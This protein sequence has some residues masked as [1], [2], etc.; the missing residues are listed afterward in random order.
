MADSRYSSSCSQQWAIPTVS[1]TVVPG[2]SLSSDS[3]SSSGEQV[4]AANPQYVVAK[5]KHEAKSTM[6]PPR[7]VA[8]T[9]QPSNGIVTRSK[10]TR[11]DKSSTMNQGQPST[12]EN[13]DNKSDKEAIQLPE[14]AQHNAVCSTS[15]KC[16]A[17]GELRL[18]HLFPVSST[19]DVPP[20][21][22][23]VG[24]KSPLLPGMTLVAAVDK[25]YL[26]DEETCITMLGFSGNCVGCGAKGFRYFTEFSQHINLRL[27]TQPKKQKHIKYYIIKDQSGRLR[28]GGVIPWKVEG[29]KRSMPMSGPS[30]ATPDEDSSTAA[31]SPSAVSSQ[32][33]AGN[34]GASQTY[35][36][37]KR[38]R[39]ESSSEN[40]AASIY[41]GDEEA[42]PAHSPASEMNKADLPNKAWLTAACGV[43]P[44]LLLCQHSIP[45]VPCCVDDIIVSDLL[46]GCFDPP[47]VADRNQFGNYSNQYHAQVPSPSMADPVTQTRTH[48]ASP[49][50]TQMAII[51]LIQH[52]SQLNEDDRLSREDIESL[53]QD[54]QLELSAGFQQPHAIAQSNLLTHVQLPVLANLAA[55]TSKGRVKIV[56]SPVSLENAI[57]RVLK[58]IME[59]IRH[60][61]NKFPKVPV[62]DFIFILATSQQKAPEFCVLVTGIS[63]ARYLT[64]AMLGHPVGARITDNLTKLEQLFRLSSDALEQLVSNY[65]EVM[66]QAQLVYIPFNGY[67]R[68]K[69]HS[70]EALT[71]EPKI[72]QSST[73]RLSKPFTVHAVQ[74]TMA[75]QL[76]SQVCSI[77]D[78]SNVL[79]ISE[80]VN[81]DFTIMVPP[82]TT[83]YNQTVQRV[84]HSGI[85]AELELEP[86]DAASKF[87][88]AQNFVIKHDD[89]EETQEKLTSLLKKVHTQPSTLFVMVFDQSQFYCNPRGVLDLPY[90]KEF[91]ESCNVIMLFVTSAPYL[92]QSNRSFIDPGNEVYWSDSKLD[93]DA[94]SITS[95]SLEDEQY[96]DDQDI[97]YFG[98]K[99]Y[100]DSIKWTHQFP[101][102]RQDDAF[103]RM[104]LRTTRATDD[105]NVSVLRC[106]LLIRHYCAAIM[107]AAGIKPAEPHCTLKTIQIIREIIETPVRNTD[108]SGTMLLIRIPSVELAGLAYDSVRNV[109]DRLGFQYRF[110]VIHDNGAG[111][112][113]IE[114]YFL[115][116]LRLWRKQRGILDGEAL[117][118]WYPRCYEELLDLPCIVLLSGRERPGETFPRSLK[119]IDIRLI[120]R[121]FLYRSSLELEFSAIACY[122]STGAGPR[123]MENIDQSDDSKDDAASN[124]SATGKTSHYSSNYPLPVVLVSRSAFKAFQT[125]F[126]GYPKHL[127]LPTSPQT[128]WL[129]HGRPHL[130]T[131]N[132]AHQSLYYRQ[133]TEPKPKQSVGC[134]SVNSRP[135][136]SMRS[137]SG[138]VISPDIPDVVEED[139]M[140]A[141]ETMGDTRQSNCGSECGE[142]SG[143]DKPNSPVQ[144]T[145]VRDEIPAKRIR[146]TND[147][148]PG[149]IMA[150]PSNPSESDNDVG[151]GDITDEESDTEKGQRFHPRS[152]LFSG[153]PQ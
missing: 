2:L 67:A 83:L 119:Y 20:M 88:T 120:D 85:L 28:K 64:E 37:A 17:G 12:H 129:G 75:K 41:S 49:L 114:E 94:C 96:T 63:Q 127:L 116:R 142:T 102:V 93:L 65:E 143:E 144:N 141:V 78:N 103:E 76:V 100:C 151:V 26:P 146:L 106:Y 25:R 77:A 51:L 79:A 43:C 56:V 87:E 115:K 99:E 31:A 72:T 133:W 57:V 153:A 61:Q 5:T 124:S 40:D 135:V 132:P 91:Q 123:T 111:E 149:Q 38:N 35:N 30:L 24:L 36:T 130:V 23:L 55:A 50:T 108:G 80:F 145:S 39:W 125:D 134:S 71:L 104:A 13:I 19:V 110:C 101:L 21:F 81:V 126:Y 4:A 147:P 1:V 137:G 152:I 136:I 33:S 9:S 86:G 29:R 73:H 45:N 74:S 131:S 32:S 8:S 112:L 14:P 107:W 97:M 54:A 150:P 138:I 98:L 70:S 34:I 109:R 113:E 15:G 48:P 84:A 90:Y 118:T 140:S 58:F 60:N 121:G 95:G 139:G 53:L 52:L 22:S 148:R 59:I 47:L 66:N 18:S 69:I 6:Q 92:F 62:P 3:K 89:C 10:H 27:A 105:V 82:I 128:R 122:I 46:V 42:S 68:M 44:V 16:Q 7:S 11:K 117:E